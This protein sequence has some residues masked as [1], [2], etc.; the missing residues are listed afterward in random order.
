MARE[1][2]KVRGLEK[3]K[4][5]ATHFE[6]CEMSANVRAEEISWEISS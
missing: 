1:N 2:A 3:G 4:D 6:R 5:G